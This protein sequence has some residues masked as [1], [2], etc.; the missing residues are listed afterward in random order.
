MGER[1]RNGRVA[2]GFFVGFLCVPSY[3]KMHGIYR[4][5]REDLLA[6]ANRT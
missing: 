4:V 1:R 2:Q 5:Y 3:I 6:H